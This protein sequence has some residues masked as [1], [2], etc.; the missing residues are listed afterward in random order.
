M[1][2][3]ALLHRIMIL[4]LSQPPR[5]W[6]DAAFVFGRAQDDWEATEGDSG[7]LE[8]AAELYRHNHVASVLIPSQEA[9]VAY[10]GKIVSTTFPGTQ[11]FRQHLEERGVPAKEIVVPGDYVPHTRAEGDAYV[12]VAK[13]RGW[14]SAVTIQHP[15][16]VARTML[17]L[18]KSF[19]VYGYEMGIVPV[20]PHLVNW[21]KPVHG[22]QGAEL[23]PRHEHIEAEWRRILEYQAKGDLATFEELEH[24]LTRN[25]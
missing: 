7:I 25:L 14:T 19:T 12:R 20:C 24:Y 5:R 17:G 18:L 21:R 15:H 3:S 11:V 9:G 8:R 6:T 4:L 22:S 16:Q 10:G 2:Q 13:E 1:N 23:L